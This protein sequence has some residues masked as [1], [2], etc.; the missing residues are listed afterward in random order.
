MSTGA[1]TLLARLAAGEVLLVT[2]TA[3]S[4]RLFC[5][6][7]SGRAVTARLA[8]AAI[9][10]DLV[11]PAGDGLFGPAFSQTWRLRRED[12]ADADTP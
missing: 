1:R 11:V 10:A 9:G 7:P 4:G 2:M 12:R 5:L 8:E 6:S 3:L